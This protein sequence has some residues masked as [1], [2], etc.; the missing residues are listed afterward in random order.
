MRMSGGDG[1][2]TQLFANRQ[3]KGRNAWRFVWL[4]FPG[5]DYWIRAAECRAR[6]ENLQQQ[7]STT[8]ST[9]SKT[10]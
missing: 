9:M 6:F 3:A 5:D 8:D 4:R 7:R 1:K 2:N 10:V